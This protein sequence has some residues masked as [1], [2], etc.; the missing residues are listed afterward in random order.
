MIGHTIAV[1]KREEI[2]SR[3]LTEQMIGHKLGEFARRVSSR[4]TA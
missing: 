3:V 1:H 4:A 2:H